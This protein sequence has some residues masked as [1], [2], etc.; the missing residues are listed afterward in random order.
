MRMATLCHRLVRDRRGAMAMIT[1]LSMPV[2]IGGVGLAADTIQWTYMKRAMQRQADS[3][4]LAGAFAMSQQSVIS[5]TVTADLARNSNVLLTVTPVIQSPPTAGAYSGDARAVRVA[6]AT[7]VR[8]PFVGFV[9][10]GPI[11]IPAE[12]TAKVVS[13]GQYCVLALETANTVGITMG[14]NTTLDLGCGMMSNSPASPSVTAGGSSLIS[15]TPIAAVGTVPI[16]GNYATGTQ[17]I[18]YSVPQFDPLAGLPTPDIKN[19]SN[20]GNVSPNGSKTLSPGNYS[21]MDIKGNVT[22][23]PGVYYIDGGVFSAGSQA[24]INGTGVTIIL[25]SKNAADSP[26]SIA[27]VNMNG[28]AT[29]NLTAPTSGTY[30]GVLFYQDRRALDSGTNIF[31]GNSSS[32]YQGAIYLPK[33]AMR[34]NGTTGMNVNCLQLIGRRLDFT[35][36]STISNV[37]PANSG[38]SSFSGTRVKLVA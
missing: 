35:G 19:S 7:D 21:G 33:Q 34:F 22:F 32:K 37:C 16:S 30:A 11:R 26:S 27:T 36:N 6:L 3:A 4:A 10:G 15:A 31:N 9:M 20:N 8:L 38:A 29:V 5:T 12:A 14:G 24:V 17:L 28:G 25:T 13:Q 2:L 23:Q 18:P 1:A